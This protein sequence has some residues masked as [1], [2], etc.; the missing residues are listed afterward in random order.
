MRDNFE[1]SADKLSAREGPP[2]TN[3]GLSRKIVASWR[4]CAQSKVDLEDLQVGEARAI[5]QV[6]FWRGV[7]A[8][9][10]PED[11]DYAL[12]ERAVWVGVK[13]AI[14][15]LQRQ[16]GMIRPSGQMDGLTLRAVEKAN[17]GDLIAALKIEG[18]NGHG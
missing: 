6:W 14:F 4:N 18:K 7:R 8:D 1:A 10:L 13:Q 12:F 5:L 2:K 3:L 17:I 9:E 11:L 15:D 16:L